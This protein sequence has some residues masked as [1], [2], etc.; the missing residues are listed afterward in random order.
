MLKI[1]YYFV[2]FVLLLNNANVLHGSLSP[3]SKPSPSADINHT[4]NAPVFV[5]SFKKMREA[6]QAVDNNSSNF[7]VNNNTTLVSVLSDRD[8]DAIL[9]NLCSNNSN[10]P[11][12]SDCVAANFTFQK[13]GGMLTLYLN[14]ST[15]ID[16]SFNVTNHN[17]MPLITSKVVDKRHSSVLDNFYGKK[18]L[19]T[20]RV[21]LPPLPKHDPH[22]TNQDKNAAPLP[23]KKKHTNTS[24]KEKPF[25]CT[26]C[27]KAFPCK[28]NLKKHLQTH[29]G[30][31]PFTCNICQKGLSSNETHQNHLNKHKNKKPHKCT[32]CTN[33]YYTNGGLK[34][35]LIYANEKDESRKCKFCEEIF[36]NADGLKQHNKKV[37]S[38]PQ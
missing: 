32:I 38:T 2:F 10:L 19:L 20:T 34:N 12:V 3:P 13:N 35:H 37:H 21:A 18:N 8:Y 24:I 27:S 11:S 7:Q 25:K 1:N 6:F 5:V 16:V 17:G 15:E 36:L 14:N 30:E 9:A 31:K 29:T 26:F 33:A 28:A 4:N 23:K 22:H